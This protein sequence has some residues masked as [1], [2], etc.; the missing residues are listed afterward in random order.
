MNECMSRAEDF[1]SSV[2]ALDGCTPFRSPS[3]RSPPTLTLPVGVT[4][5]LHW[6]RPTSHPWKWWD[7]YKHPWEAGKS[8]S[9]SLT[10]PFPPEQAVIQQGPWG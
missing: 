2:G 9:L 5:D 3:L 4:V 10:A 6:G 1:P 7:G 8:S